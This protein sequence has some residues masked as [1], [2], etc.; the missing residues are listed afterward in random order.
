MYLCLLQRQAAHWAG[1]QIAAF[2]VLRKIEEMFQLGCASSLGVSTNFNI[3][4]SKKEKKRGVVVMVKKMKYAS[5]V[6]CQITGQI[7][8]LEEALFKRAFVRCNPLV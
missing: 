6:T 5:A 2:L 1:M 4:D 7:R 8:C 3:T